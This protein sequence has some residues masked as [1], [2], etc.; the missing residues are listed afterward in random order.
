MSKNKYIVLKSPNA[1]S[2]SGGIVVLSDAIGN[3]SL[4]I[5]VFGINDSDLELLVDD[6]VFVRQFSLHQKYCQFKLEK[7]IDDFTDIVVGVFNKN[8]ELLLVGSTIGIETK[9]QKERLEIALENKMS[10]KHFGSIARQAIS[11]KYKT[12][13]DE[14]IMIVLDLFACG[15]PDENLQKLIPD[16][17]WVK[18]FCEKDVIAVGVVE[19]EGKLSEI[20]LAFPVICKQQKRQEVDSNFAFLPLSENCPNGFGY[21]VVLQ[22]AKDGTVVPMNA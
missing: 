10:L 8:R 17:R 9:E 14:I 20:G 5:S 2:G 13:F 11:K 1:K 16:S 15:F 21:Y 22:R 7:N 3:T 4:T 18:V 19:S 12:F 6:L